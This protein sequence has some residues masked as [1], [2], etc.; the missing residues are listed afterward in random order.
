M[1]LY[2][3]NAKKVRLE[4]LENPNADEKEIL[5]K[6]KQFNKAIESDL[7]VDIKHAELERKHAETSKLKTESI[8]EIAGTVIKGVAAIGT[9]GLGIYNTKEHSGA[10]VKL[11]KTS[12]HKEERFSTDERDIEGEIL[13]SIKVK[14]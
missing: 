3:V 5:E 13:K 8:C 1:D 14:D 2:L 12:F 7:D 4:E 9:I 10:L 6:Y 11:I